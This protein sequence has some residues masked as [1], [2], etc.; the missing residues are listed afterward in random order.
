MVI[1]MKKD[2][3]KALKIAIACCLSIM[4]AEMLNLDFSSSA[5]ITALLTITDSRKKTLTLA[6]QRLFSFL[7]SIFVAILVFQ[8]TQIHWITF[9][10]Y[11]FF[12]VWI[13]YYFHWHGTISVNAVMGTHI[14]FSPKVTS[15]FII[16]E[17]Y[18]IFIGS[19]FAILLN[20]IIPKKTYKELINEDIHYIENSFISLFREINKH[21]VYQQQLKLDDNISKLENYIENAMQTAIEN[22]ENINQEESKKYVHYCDIRLEQ[23]YLFE[24]I[25]FKFKQI[26]NLSDVDV[27]NLTYLINEIIDDIASHNK[28]HHHKNQCRL[29]KETFFHD[30]DNIEDKAILYGVVLDLEEFIEKQIELNQY[31]Q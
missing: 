7:V 14:L 4:V 21:L 22:N 23:V 25:S 24:N 31:K 3:I 6:M 27:I 18:I 17:F 13:S 5:G 10:I 30:L 12:I 28:P 1:K 2:M 9:G 26:N 19:A 15:A 11:I 8:A 20:M 29:I 16:N